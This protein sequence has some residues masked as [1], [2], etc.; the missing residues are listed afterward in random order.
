MLPFLHLPQLLSFHLRR[1]C[2][3]ESNGNRSAGRGSSPG[4]GK[5]SPSRSAPGSGSAAP[6]PRKG[7]TSANQRDRSGPLPGGL[8][9]DP[10]DVRE[11]EA[12]QRQEE[13][14]RRLRE[15]DQAERR[16]QERTRRKQLLCDKRTLNQLVVQAKHA[17]NA[18]QSKVNRIQR[19]LE[20]VEAEVE[21]LTS[22]KIKEQERLEGILRQLVEEQ[23]QL[24]VE[25]RSRLDEAGD[26]RAQLVEARD[27]G[28]Q[29]LQ[30]RFGEVSDA[31][32]KLQ[33][34][35]QAIHRLSDI[36]FWSRSENNNDESP[37]RGAASSGGRRG[38]DAQRGGGGSR[39][40]LRDRA[41]E[42]SQSDSSPTRGNVTDLQAAEVVEMH[43]DP[44]QSAQAWPTAVAD[45]QRAPGTLWPAG[46]VSTTTALPTMQIGS[47]TLSLPPPVGSNSS[48]VVQGVAQQRASLTAVSSGGLIIPG[49]SVGTVAPH[50]PTATGLPGRGGFTVVPPRG[51]QA[52]S[53]TWASRDIQGSSVVHLVG[54]PSPAMTATTATSAP[55]PPQPSANAN[56]GRNSSRQNLAQTPLGTPTAPPPGS[57]GPTPNVV[58]APAAPSIAGYVAGGMIRQPSNSALPLS[59]IANEKVAT[60]WSSASYPPRV[61]A[62]PAPTGYFNQPIVVHTQTAT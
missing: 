7:T 61:A 16:D 27:H 39:A 58:A 52:G 54:D 9:S 10:G 23:K 49:A 59:A 37:T 50:H 4:R 44:S 19:Q 46:A 14:E 40:D 2:R 8:F 18:Q 28:E 60:G 42:P 36:D 38:M 41:R 24:E 57:G 56:M 20:K 26:A 35:E 6:G 12:A 32:F 47:T 17:A 51:G 33:Q 55:Q 30:L 25:Y 21:R 45:F 5:R 29:E 62:V 3:T 1:R 43:R 34:I 48:V 13:W 31:E 15:R 11:P 22:R 53:P